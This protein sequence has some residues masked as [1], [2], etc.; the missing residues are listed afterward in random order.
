MREIFKNHSVNQEIEKNGFA[1]V[2]FIDSKVIHE[3]KEFYKS[4]PGSNALGTHVTMFNPSVEYRRKVNDKIN[5]LCGDTAVSLMNGY[6]VLYTNYM[7]KE[8]GKEGD[9]PVHQ[10]WTYVDE[11]KHTSI[12][13]WIPLDEVDSENGA[14]HV[15]K[16]SHKFISALRGPFVHEPFQKLSAEIK[17]QYSQPINLK[18]GEALAW[19]HRLIHFS[20]PNKTNQPRI[21]ITLIMVPE[22]TDVYHCFGIPE[23]NG[24][25]V[26]KFNVDTD[27]Y[28]NYII[29]KR[30]QRVKLLETFEQPAENFSK[31]QFEEAYN[32]QVTI[33]N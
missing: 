11:S 12:A 16:G 21:A 15:V 24:T 2:P 23:S 10:D 8:P 25:V 27:F 31:E 32:S 28:M 7:I 14:L 6:R 33:A 26:E 1:V 30:P 4:L 17:N 22:N 29:G 5:E 18:A 3:L 19:D 9:F 20:L 13:F